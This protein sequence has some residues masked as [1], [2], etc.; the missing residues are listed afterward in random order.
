MVVLSNEAL[1][2]KTIQNFGDFPR[3]RVAHTI[4]VTYQTTQQQLKAIPALIEAAIR[5]TPPAEFERCLFTCMANSALEFEFVFF[6]PSSDMLLYLQLQQS[7]IHYIIEVFANQGIEFA[8]P[9]Q[10]LFVQQS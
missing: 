7:I 4:G 1:L 6:V 5:A 8:Y 10:T 9:T 3:R 2:S